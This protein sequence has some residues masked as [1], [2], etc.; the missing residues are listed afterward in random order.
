M[1]ICEYRRQ[2]CGEKFDKLVRCSAD[3]TDLSCPNCG[4]KQAEKLLSVFG[5]SGF[6]T[7][8]NFASSAERSCQPS[9]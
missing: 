3:E 9:G 8:R 2:Q 7:T 6:S 5:T 4:S 1:P